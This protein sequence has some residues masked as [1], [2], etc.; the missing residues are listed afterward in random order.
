MKRSI[1]E[2][3]AG[4]ALVLMGVII[5]YA[6][7]PV[8]AESA[9]TRTSGRISEIDMTKDYSAA[10]NILDNFYTGDLNKKAKN[11]APVYLTASEGDQSAK[12]AEVKQVTAKKLASR[13]PPLSAGTNE[14]SN[15]N[16][17]PAGAGTLAAGVLALGAASVKKGYWSNYGQNAATVWN[18]ATHPEETYNDFQ[19]AHEYEQSQHTPT[20]GA[21]NGVH[22]D[23][24]PN[25]HACNSVSSSGETNCN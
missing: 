18:A 3:T 6:E 8:T 21:P 1:L 5:G 13:V 14:T 7:E 11:A 12:I 9:L 17:F 16:T 19:A 25:D 10:Q 20:P 15:G 22:P 24:L 23:Q 2:M 4:V